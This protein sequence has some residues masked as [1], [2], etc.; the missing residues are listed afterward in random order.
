MFRTLRGRVIATYFIVVIISLLLA[1]VFFLFFLT[2]YTRNRDKNDLLREVTALAKDVK[3]LEGGTTS[4]PAAGRQVKPASSVTQGVINAEGDV[5]AAKLLVVVRD[6]TVVLQSSNGPDLGSSIDLPAG[7]FSKGPLITE[8]YFKGLGR[9]YLFATAPTRVGVSQG[10]LMALKPVEQVGSVAGSLVGYLVIAGLIALAASMLLALYLSGALSRPIREVTAAARKMSAGDYWVEVPVRG[11]DET[12][13]LARDFNDMAGRVR[14]AYEQQRNFVANVSH[15]LR[16]PL[17]SIEGFSQALLDGVSRSEEEKHRSLEIIN[18]ESKR[19]V[20]V[21]RD[22]LLLSQIDAGD[23]RP[24]K[25]PTGLVDMMHHLESVYIP[26][27]EAEGITLRV[28]PPGPSL[29]I[30]TDPDRLERVLTNLMDNALKYSDEEGTVTLSAVA[31]EDSV[32]ISVADT[33]PGIAPDVLPSI[34]DRFYR[35]EKSRSKKHGG[36]GLGLSISKELVWTLGGTISVKSTV[37]SGTT[38]T[39]TVPIS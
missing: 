15:E 38:F 32:E 6:G 23:L 26:R 14:N 13:E 10:Y 18:V 21:L 22:L 31:T 27:A 2:R 24:D 17:T 9:D 16:T 33:G 25:R 7:V 8:H 37:G 29:T 4:V 5:L 30:F 36:T 19:L 34:F 20:R 12:A 1:S 35:V 28:I 3:A 11:S 39:V